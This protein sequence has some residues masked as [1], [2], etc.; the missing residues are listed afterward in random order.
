MGIKTIPRSALIC[1]GQF[2]LTMKLSKSEDLAC[3]LTLITDKIQ[4]FH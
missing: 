4:R 2:L 3:N 1:D